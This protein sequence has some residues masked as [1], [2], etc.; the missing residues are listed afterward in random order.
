MAATTTPVTFVAADEA[1][2]DRGGELA[3]RGGA[4]QRLVGEREPGCVAERDRVPGGRQGPL[5]VVPTGDAVRDD[6]EEGGVVGPQ[7]LRGDG[8]EG[9]QLGGGQPGRAEREQ[10]GG[11]EVRRDLGVERELRRVA[12]VG[13]VAADDHDRVALRGD[14]VEALHDALHR[15]GG[16]GVDVLVGHAG[17]LVVRQA[18]GVVADEEVEDVVAGAAVGADDGPEH[19]DP[20]DAT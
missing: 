3:H 10:H 17:A 1:T 11:A 13:E 8:R 20:L 15:G 5:P 12:D 7:L 18:D 6:A 14:G 2:V 16:V 9:V 4:E 19:A